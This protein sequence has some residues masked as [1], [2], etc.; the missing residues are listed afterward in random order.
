[1][2]VLVTGCCGFIGF[3]LCVA[4]MK[5]DISVVGIDNLNDYYD[6]NLKKSRLSKLEHSLFTFY[7]LDINNISKINI[8]SKKFDIVVNLAAQA[9]VR[10]KKN[11]EHLYET[12]NVIG[13][14]NVCKFC[15]ENGIDKI[16][17]ASSSS[18]YS[19]KKYEKF[20]EEK[21]IIDPKSKYGKSKYQNEIYADLVSKKNKL[22]MIGLRFFSVYGP[23]G[24][25]DMA[26]Y[27]FTDSIENNKVINLN[28][29]GSML[30][31]MT[32][33]D[34][35]IDGVIGS[36]DFLIKKNTKNNHIFNL[37]NDNPIQTKKLLSNIA[38]KLNKK[39]QIRNK[40]SH[41]ESAFTHSDNSK[42]KK[43]LRYNPKTDLSDGLDKF[44]SWYKD[45]YGKQ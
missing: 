33:I 24:R 13:F 38:E 16:I 34:D 37:G 4:L 1:M 9:G 11:Q 8:E 29:D 45:Y 22:S 43:Y 41:S 39:P 2:K 14:K 20:N 44:I 7:N 35:V 21:T 25:P 10:V 36:I 18:V 31:D 12:T 27:I 23:Y 15:V 30:R 17:Y 32:Y 40:I 3:H 6:Q 28:N 19:D 26:Y 42:A 5:K